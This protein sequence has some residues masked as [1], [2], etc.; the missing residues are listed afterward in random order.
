M[1]TSFLCVSVLRV[2]SGPRVKFP[3]PLGVW[4]RLR[5]VIVELP[6]LFSY[7]FL[8]L[9]KVIN[10]QDYNEINTKITDDQDHK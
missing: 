3:I 9:D 1:R 4:E 8:S 10:N 7:L 5:F 2:A 6:G